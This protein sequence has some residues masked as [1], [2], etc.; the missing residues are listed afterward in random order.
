MN[1]FGSGVY[2]T[3]CCTEIERTL[4]VKML[5]SWKH[6]LVH[7]MSFFRGILCFASSMRW[8]RTNSSD[9]ERDSGLR[10]SGSLVKAF[11]TAVFLAVSGSS[12]NFGRTSIASAFGMYPKIGTMNLESPVFLY[13][14]WTALTN[15][16]GRVAASAM[17]CSI[18][19]SKIS[20]P[21]GGFSTTTTTEGDDGG[22]SFAK[23]ITFW[24]MTFFWTWDALANIDRSSCSRSCFLVHKAKKSS[25]WRDTSPS[26]TPSL[27]VVSWLKALSAN[28]SMSPCR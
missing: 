26:D 10:P 1:N 14:A 5:L 11:T 16:L 24:F 22:I 20:D 21:L 17:E 12:T 19:S 3:R 8:R 7:S 18:R 2:C 27:A 28:F 25:M 23:L 13:R 9:A 4:G 15:C 6:M